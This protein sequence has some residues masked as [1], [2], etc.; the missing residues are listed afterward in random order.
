MLPRGG[1]Y[2]GQ[3]ASFERGVGLGVE[4][5]GIFG[6]GVFFWRGGIATREWELGAVRPCNHTW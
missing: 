6:E 4:E 3:A 5:G 2:Q 1:V